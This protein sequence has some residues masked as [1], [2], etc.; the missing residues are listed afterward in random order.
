MPGNPARDSEDEHLAEMLELNNVP[1]SGLNRQDAL[2]LLR[3]ASDLNEQLKDYSENR[4]KLR[5]FCAGFLAGKISGE[6]K[7]DCKKCGANP[8]CLGYIPIFLMPNQ[9]SQPVQYF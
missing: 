8:T 9:P 2:K 1:A 7:T 4:L 5:A 6:Y 3:F